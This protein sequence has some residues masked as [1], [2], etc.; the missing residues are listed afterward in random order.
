MRPTTSKRCWLFLRPC[1]PLRR[2]RRAEGHR[3]VYLALDEGRNTQGLEA[4]VRMVMAEEGCERFAYQL[5][6]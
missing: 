5:A 1:G 3:V 2:A 4:N 6:R